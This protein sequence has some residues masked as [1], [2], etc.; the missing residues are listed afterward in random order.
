MYTRL[1]DVLLEVKQAGLADSIQVIPI[2]VNFKAD[3]Q[4]RIRSYRR[5]STVWLLVEPA[6]LKRTGR[7]YA[8]A[9]DQA[10]ADTGICFR[11]RAATS[12]ADVCKALRSANCS[13]VIVNNSLWGTLSESTKKMDRVDRPLYEI[14]R[15]SLEVARVKAGIF[16]LPS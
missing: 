10:F 5:G 9:Y 8:D 12:E 11:V 15:A 16:V 1:K 13:L 14:D 3:V 7:A 4:R 2:R 6:V